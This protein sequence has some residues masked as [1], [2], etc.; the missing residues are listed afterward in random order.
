MTIERTAHLEGAVDLPDGAIT[1]QVQRILRS[2]QFAQSARLSRFLG[3]EDTILYS[4]CFDANAGLF[5]HRNG[6]GDGDLRRLME[7]FFSEVFVLNS[8]YCNLV[9]SGNLA[10]KLF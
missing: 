8:R 7:S 6:H 3:M 9:I 10:E 2:S 4:S 1:E 5:D